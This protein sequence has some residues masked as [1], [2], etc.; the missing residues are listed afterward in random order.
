MV[1]IIITLNSAVTGDRPTRSSRVR[2]LSYHIDHH[3]E[4]VLL[5]QRRRQP[6]LHAPSQPLQPQNASLFL[7]S[8]CKSVKTVTMNR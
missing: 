3:I 5:Q 1:F 2:F 7:S 6:P 4:E 8:L